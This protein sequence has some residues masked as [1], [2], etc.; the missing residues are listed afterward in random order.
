LND[1]QLTRAV[2][3]ALHEL[4]LRED[5]LAELLAR[6][7]NERL[8]Y[9]IGADLTTSPPARLARQIVAILANRRRQ[10][11]LESRA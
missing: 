6:H 3:S 1:K 8:A 9:F 10:L 5:A 2:N 7:P 4:I 11:R